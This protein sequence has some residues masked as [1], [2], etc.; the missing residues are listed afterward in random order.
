MCLTNF[1]YVNL[2]YFTSEGCTAT[3]EESKAVAE[4]SFS[5]TN[6][7]GVLALKLIPSFKAY[8][9]IVK[10]KDLTWRQMMT[11]KN[12][13]LRHMGKLGWPEKHINAITLTAMKLSLLSRPKFD[14]NG[15]MLWI[16]MTVSISPK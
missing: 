11:G 7:N 2:F 10:D 12:M 9:N 13:M 14:E 3:S 6:D 1:K 5:I 8:K 16:G 15:M 4:E